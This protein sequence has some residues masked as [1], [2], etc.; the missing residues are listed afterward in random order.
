MG[1]IT[2]HISPSLESNRVRS[3]CYVEKEEE[4]HSDSLT[5]MHTSSSSKKRKGRGDFPRRRLWRTGDLFAI[6]L[7]CDQ[8]DTESYAGSIQTC[9]L[10]RRSLR[11]ICTPGMNGKES[12]LLKKKANLPNRGSIT[13]YLA[14]TRA[15]NV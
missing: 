5:K 10:C 15:K 4:M 11:K 1:K 12:I 3:L 7:S 8:L 13:S 14:V 6:V 9:S 2:S